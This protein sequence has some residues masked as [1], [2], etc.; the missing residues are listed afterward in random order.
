MQALVKLANIYIG[1]CKQN[2]TTPNHSILRMIAK[3]LTKMLK[4]F[5]AN[6]GSQEIGFAASGEGAGVANVG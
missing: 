2:E 1:Q 5:G 3:Y 4:V 6:E